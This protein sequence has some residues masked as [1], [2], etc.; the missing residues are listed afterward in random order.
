VSKGTHIPGKRVLAAIACGAALLAAGCGSDNEGKDVPAG[1]V[2]DLKQSL[3]SI[4]N[5]V[6]A[7]PAACKEVTE[8]DDTDVSAVQS[9]IDALPADVDK[10]VRDALEESFR[11]L[12][13]LVEDECDKQQTE[14]TP[15]ETTPTV[16]ETTP[17]VTETTPTETTPTTTPTTTEKQKGP[18]KPKENGP[19]NSGGEAAP[20]GD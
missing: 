10:D 3:D 8:G 12:F 17:T 14:T 20:G 7:G 16:T 6:N 11:T 4:Q 19:G 1:S 5:R 9:K 15:T 13:R 2:A 18:K